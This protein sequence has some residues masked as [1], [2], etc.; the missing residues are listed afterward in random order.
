MNVR[1]TDLPG[2]WE[3]FADVASDE[4]GHFFRLNDCQML[5][6]LVGE[7]VSTYSAISHNT[8]R[9]TLR[10]MHWQSSAAPEAKLVRCVRGSALDVVVDVD[11]S[12]KTFGRWTAVELDADR[13][14][15]VLIGP[16]HAHGFLTLADSTD[17]LYEIRGSYEPSSAL[18]FRW[19]DPMVGIDWPAVPA[20]IGRRDAVLPPLGLLNEQRLT[21]LN[22]EGPQ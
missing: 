7:W 3:V 10:G 6:S 22:A 18:G 9:H 13:A 15:A 16:L 12:S 17:V 8:A 19:D 1:A 11:S 5:S 20:V 4:R 21:V 14:N 2:A